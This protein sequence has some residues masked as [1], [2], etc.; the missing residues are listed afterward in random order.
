MIDVII[1]IF[2]VMV[3]FFFGSIC[4]NCIHDEV[5]SLEDNHEEDITFCAN[6]IDNPYDKDFSQCSKCGSN[7]EKS[8]IENCNMN[9]CPNCGARM[10]EPQIER[11][12]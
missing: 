9:F 3:G 4:D 2:F 8:I 6:W 10:V 5:C 11:N 12:R 1:L 7:W